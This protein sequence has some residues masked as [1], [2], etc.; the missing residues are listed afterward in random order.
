M[1]TGRLMTRLLQQF[2]GKRAVGLNQGERGSKHEEYWAVLDPSR[3]R[4]TGICCQNGREQERKK[5]SKVTP[6]FGA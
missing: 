6:R 3:G 1:Q 5:E 4:A 2:R